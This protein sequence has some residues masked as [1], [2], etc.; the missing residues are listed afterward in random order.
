M[1]LVLPGWYWDP[2]GNVL[3][4]AVCSLAERV[5]SRPYDGHKMAFSALKGHPRVVFHRLAAHRVENYL[6]LRGSSACQVL[7]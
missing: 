7:L 4:A 5:G 1:T 3:E 6:K 2:V